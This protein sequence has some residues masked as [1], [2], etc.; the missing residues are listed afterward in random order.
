[1]LVTLVVYSG[2]VDPRWQ[3]VLSPSDYQSIQSRGYSPDCMPAKLYYKGFLVQDP[4]RE[5]LII[6]RDVESVRLQHL[7]FQTMPAGVIPSSLQ[8]RVSNEIGVVLAA[9]PTAKRKRHAPPY[10]PAFRNG[11]ANTRLNNNCYN[12]ANDRITNT[13]AQPGRGGRQIFNQLNGASVR[14]AS[15]RDGLRVLNPHPGPAAPV[16]GA[17]AGPQHLVALFVEPG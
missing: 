16:P 8:Q 12:Y 17:P 9:C 15:I 10:N 3:A 2:L 5:L 11:N 4:A 14:D 7:L 13:F 1:M 6:G